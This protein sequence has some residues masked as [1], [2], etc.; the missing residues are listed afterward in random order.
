M[1][2]RA[3][4]EDVAAIDRVA[5]ARTVRWVSHATRAIPSPPTSRI[6]AMTIVP[7]IASMNVLSR[8]TLQDPDM[9]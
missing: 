1:W 8:P 3:Q 4:A 5:K 7:A 9:P 2:A 6:S